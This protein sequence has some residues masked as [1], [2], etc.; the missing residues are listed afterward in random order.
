MLVDLLKFGLILEFV[1]RFLIFVILEFL[2]KDVFIEILI[3]F[4]NVFV[5]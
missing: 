5:K 4:K 2:D 3:K 1:G